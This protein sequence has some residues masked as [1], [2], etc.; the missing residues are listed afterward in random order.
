MVH[1][2]RRHNGN[3]R[4][5]AKRATRPDRRDCLAS[6]PAS[7]P[8]YV[9]RGTSCQSA[10]TKRA[11]QVI[12]AWDNTGNTGETIYWRDGYTHLRMMARKS[13]MHVHDGPAAHDVRVIEG[14]TENPIASTSAREFVRQLHISRMDK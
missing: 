5:L 3:A 2:G 13:G 9:T 7:P 14:R 6:S 12:D 1:V 10:S 8:V 11:L 4:R